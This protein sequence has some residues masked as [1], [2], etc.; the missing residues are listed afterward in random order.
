MKTKPARKATKKV[1]ATVKTTKKT[2]KQSKVA[3]TNRVRKEA[4]WLIGHDVKGKGYVD[5]QIDSLRNHALICGNTGSGK[6]NTCF[7]ML[8]E[9][10]KKQ[11]PFLVIEPAKSEYRHL[12]MDS[13][14]LR[15]AAK[16]YTAGEDTLSSFRINPFEIAAGVNVQSHIDA[17]LA[18]F[19]SCFEM[20]APMPQVLNKAICSLYQSRGWDLVQNRNLRLPEGVSHGEPGCPDGIFP[21]MKDLYDC[22]EPITESFGYSERIGPDVNAALKARIG[23]LI[24]G[25][26]G[27][28]FA[29][30]SSEVSSSLFNTPSVLEL[31]DKFNNCEK[32]FLCGVLMLFLYEHR[33]A[34]G[35][36]TKLE[37]LLLIEDAHR[38]LR[39][40]TRRFS[41]D[42]LPFTPF[43]SEIFVNLLSESS[44][45]GEGVVISSQS[46]AI[47]MPEILSNTNLKIVHRLL[48]HDDLEAIAPPGCLSVK[49]F[50]DIVGLSTGEALVLDKGFDK[51]KKVKVSSHKLRTS[52]ANRNVTDS[53]NALREFLSQ[54]RSLKQTSVF[55]V[56]TQ[57]ELSTSSEIRE[58]LELA[59]LVAD[60][61][62]FRMV[63]NRYVLS[64]LVDLTQL[65]HFRAQVIHEIQRI[66]GGRSR[67]PKL[68]EITWCVL[69]L[70]SERYFE[71][72]GEEQFWSF[73]EL[74][75]QKQNW[76]AMMVPAFQ[77]SAMNRRLD[78][79]ELRK[80]RDDFLAL[81]SRDQGPYATCGACTKKC[82]YRFEL[83]EVTRD[84]KIRFDFNSSINRT[85]SSASD[86]AAWFCRLLCE[87]LIGQFDLDI[88]YCLAVHF[89][90]EQALSTDAQL[91][92]LAKVRGL[93][94]SNFK[95]SESPGR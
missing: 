3:S 28:V 63:M 79:L 64:L 61:Y 36:S 47:L 69:V 17:L 44:S 62:Q 57:A 21:T 93:L 88:A 25:A 95:E 34:L 33:K 41:S 72:K 39:R 51:A 53:S 4:A 10:W 32:S 66:I 84:P 15:S 19:N 91:V 75:I 67:S 43:V 94:E 14:S 86:S 37:H 1:N 78:I 55:E 18:I 6:T 12:I 2:S 73:D 49:E 7:N 74:E 42:S 26:K 68:T 11:I 5:C 23:D 22:I 82:H 9:V 46:P 70:A 35:A 80:W 16:I 52:G 29:L 38:M 87:R 8:E 89:I 27:C 40:E 54:G 24:I 85:D 20:Y 81:Q 56:R 83:S 60:D 13:Q 71:R 59:T 92:L 48:T 65:V 50:K 58:I 77:L 31:G 45:Y 90:K 76:L 30:R